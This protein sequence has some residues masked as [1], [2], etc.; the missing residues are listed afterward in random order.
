MAYM[1]EQNVY[2]PFNT[3]KLSGSVHTR[4]SNLGGI[5]PPF[6]K[7]GGEFQ[8]QGGNSEKHVQSYMLLGAHPPLLLKLPKN[9]KS[10]NF[11]KIIINQI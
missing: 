8:K 7:F 5:S 11:S 6:E 2:Q 4:I 9:L 1:R 3:G 10:F